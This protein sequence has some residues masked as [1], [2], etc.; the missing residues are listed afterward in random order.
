[1]NTFCVSEII[2]A[3]SSH[4]SMMMSKSRSAPSRANCVL[5]THWGALICHP[6][7]LERKCT[8]FSLSY[9]SMSFQHPWSSSQVHP[10]AV[11]QGTVQKSWQAVSDWWNAA[12]NCWWACLIAFKICWRP[13]TGH[14]QCS[15]SLQSMLRISWTC[16]TK[17][18]PGYTW[19]PV[20]I[21]LLSVP[22]VLQDLFLSSS[23][24][25]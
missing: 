16:V 10:G 17:S 12:A 14:C 21:S 6:A 25:S 22:V 13:W 2:I 15:K 20:R 7:V 11:C 19:Q 24:T 9:M 8:S 23:K 3:S 1:M 18:T 5:E 4:Q